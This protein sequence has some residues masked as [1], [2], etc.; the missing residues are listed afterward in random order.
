MVLTND[1]EIKSCDDVELDIKRSSKL[2]FKLSFDDSKDIKAIVCVVAGIGADASSSYKDHL[3]TTIA[4]KLDV[5]VLCVDYH[6][7][8]INPGFG[9]VYS[10]DE[11]DKLIFKAVS[12]EIGFKLPLDFDEKVQNEDYLK[13]I[14]SQLDYFVGFLKEHNQLSQNYKAPIHV[15]FK[16]ARGEYQNMGI[17]S[18]TDIINALLFVR[19]KLPF[20]SKLSYIPAIL[21]GSSHGGYV[22]NIAAKI[23]PWCVEA[24]VDNSSW[25]LNA[26]VTLKDGALNMI[27]YG[28]EIDYTEYPRV[29]VLTPNIEMNISNTTKWTSQKSSPYFFSPSRHQIRNFNNLEQLKI[30]EPRT[31]YIGYHSKN[32]ELEKCEKKIEFYKNLKNLGFDA[33]L[34]VIDDESKIDGKLIKN[35]EHGMNMSIKELILK[36]VPKLLKKL[37]N[38]KNSDNNSVCYL[39][40]EWKYIFK[41]KAHKLVLSCEK[42]I[43]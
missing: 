31:I 25:N 10:L 40:D 35:L 7:I 16:P 5:A 24:V 41:E 21:V 3:A 39:T 19:K 30:Q 1:Y 37:K 6:C 28:K 15:T 12:K 8:G 18:A 26:D 13:H 27:G 32:D 29:K 14:I 20:K 34:N 4:S 38:T 9:A 22:A 36:E 17:M 23:A 42:R 2:K 11:I 33:T 43:F